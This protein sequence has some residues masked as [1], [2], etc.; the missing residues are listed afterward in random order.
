MTLPGSMKFKVEIT[1]RADADLDQAYRYIRDHD[2]PA[3]AAIWRE[4]LYPV[5][6][7]LGEFPRR[8]GHAPENS[9]SRKEVRQLHYK[10]YRVLFTIEGDRVVVFHIR[11]AARLP[12]PPEDLA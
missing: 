12:L 6:E 11:H 1:A 7:R 4:G 8:F 10:S 2:G 3:R 5:M 9:G